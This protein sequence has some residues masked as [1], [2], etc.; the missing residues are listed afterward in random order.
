MENISHIFEEKIVHSIVENINTIFKTNIGHTPRE[1][2]RIN[3]GVYISHSV[4]DGIGARIDEV[5]ILSIRIH[6]IWRSILKD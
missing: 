6:N 4:G 1:N 2:V 5:I 3:V